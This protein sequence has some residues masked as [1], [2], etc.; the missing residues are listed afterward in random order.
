MHSCWASFAKTGKPQ[1]ASGPAWP[2]Y[3]PQ[4]D[5]LMEFGVDSGVRQGFRKPQLDTQE[6]RYSGG[7]GPL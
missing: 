7:T 1:C 5:Q 4:S 2:A 6:A 3:T